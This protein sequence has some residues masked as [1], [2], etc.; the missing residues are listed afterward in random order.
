MW[1]SDLIEITS[2][3]MNSYEIC[4]MTMQTMLLNNEVEKFIGRL[5]DGDNLSAH[6]LIDF[7]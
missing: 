5:L 1:K 3:F 4:N 7:D 6:Q 2:Q